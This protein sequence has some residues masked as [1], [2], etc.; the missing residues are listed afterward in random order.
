METKGKNPK[1]ETID[2]RREVK[3][4][5]NGAE[6]MNFTNDHSWEDVD[7]PAENE[8]KRREDT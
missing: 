4:G 1:V 2:S 3:F 5:K 6:E 7:K 8:R